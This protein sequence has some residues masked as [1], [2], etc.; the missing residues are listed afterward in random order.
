MNNGRLSNHICLNLLAV[1]TGEAG[2]GGRTARCWTASSGYCVRARGGKIYLTAFPH[3]R[4]ATEGS[5]SG[6][7]TAVCG[8]C[9]KPSLKTFRHAAS[10]I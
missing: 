10:L 5:N 7:E 4:P 6:S 1:K 9:S 2:R 8:A 3:T